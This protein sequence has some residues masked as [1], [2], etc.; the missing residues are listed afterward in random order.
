MTRERDDKAHPVFAQAGY[1][2]VRVD[3]RGT[4]DSD[5]LMHDEYTQQELQDGYDVIYNSFQV[6]AMRPP[7]LKAILPVMGTDDR[8]EEDIHF[9]GGV[10]ATDNFWWGSIMQLLNLSPPDPQI[11][12]DQWRELW[13]ERLDANTSWIALWTEHQTNDEMWKHGS[14]SVNYED[15]QVP[16][17]YFG[18]WSDLYCDTPFRIAA[19]LNS[20][21]KVLMGP[22]AHV[23]PHDGVPGPNIDFLGEAIRWWDYWLKGID[24]GIMD[25]PRLRFYLMESVEPQ[26]TMDFRPGCW[27]QDPS[28]PS[29]N[30]EM[31]QLWLNDNMLEKE[32]VEGQAMSICSPQNYGAAAGDAC[33]FATPGD[34]PVDCRMD[35]AGALQFRSAPLTEPLDILGQVQLHLKVAA[36]QTQA[37]VTAVLADEAPD[38]SLRLVTRGIFNLCHR[39]SNER[40][41]PVV[42][43]EEMAVTVPLWAQR[44]P[45]RQPHPALN[46]ALP[47][48]AKAPM[49]GLLPLTSPRVA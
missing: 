43:G 17:Y 6:A 5:G 25:E 10:M 42:P 11:V 21:C 26:G 3:M 9:R 47:S 29:P 38:G 36:D 48:S 20:P 23:Y 18:G 16:V 44:L 19:N 41:V 1:G 28:W 33:S 32:P 40:V 31:K 49:S 4:G 46:P 7:A 13:Q 15:V 27:V 24:N 12:G 35:A 30:V 22:W 37:F 34:L 14:I 39:E 8:W 45:C 2:A